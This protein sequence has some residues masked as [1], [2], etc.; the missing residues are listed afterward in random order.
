MSNTLARPYADYFPYGVSL[1]VPN[2]AYA[3]DVAL[4]GP[5]CANFGAPLALDTDGILDGVTMVN[6]S[7]VTISA[8]TDGVATDTAIAY[9]GLV[10]FDSTSKFNG[11]GR[12]VTAVASST[13]TR[14]MTVTGYDYL[15]S[16]MVEN[17]TLN[18]STPVV[19]VKAFAWIASISFA[20]ASDTTTV[21]VGWGN[22][23]GLPYAL[24]A[25]DVETKNG[26][27]AA[28]A[29]TV[30]AAL[31]DATAATATNADV[32]GTYTPATVLPNGTNT[33]E[34]WYIPRRNN[35]HGNAQYA[36]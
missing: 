35:L 32:R 25:L 9:N 20:S 24:T 14:V 30:V 29:G 4:N 19:G 21:D 13:N 27:V 16:K 1:R 17:L 34:L 28:N 5:F 33:F 12:N 15:G 36:G 10:P 11:W 26:A 22:A 31:A 2:L 7:A 23:F 6:G 8:F 3:A 18:S